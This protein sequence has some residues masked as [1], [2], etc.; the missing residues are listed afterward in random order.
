MF[1]KSIVFILSF[2]VVITTVFSPNTNA[3][4]NSNSQLNKEDLEKI[5]LDKVDNLD[6][7]L[8]NL[9]LNR[10][11]LLDNN[12]RIKGENYGFI[13]AKDSNGTYYNFY[14]EG[15]T[16]NYYSIQKKMDNSN[17]SFVLYDMNQN[18]LLDSEIN[19]NG[20][21]V[22]ENVA[23]GNGTAFRDSGINKAAFKWA[24]IFSSEV[25][26][27][28]VAAG[29]GAAGSVVSGPFGAAAGFAGGSACKYIFRTAVEKYGS[30]DKA[31][32]ILG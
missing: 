10:D 13:N 27:V 29:A 8:S 24:C 28:G 23:Q 1:K 30:K 17:S 19:Q 7:A 4:S 18:Y 12:N 14:L 5:D 20:E 9:N 32:S 11:N 6:S 15:N 2:L 3:E 31:C 22:E 26:C 16:I 25:A 21:V